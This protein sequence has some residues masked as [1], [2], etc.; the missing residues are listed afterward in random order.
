MVWLIVLNQPRQ[1]PSFNS[2]GWGQSAQPSRV[3]ITIF[4]LFHSLARFRRLA[5]SP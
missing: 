3:R 2:D 4:S 1:L 5:P